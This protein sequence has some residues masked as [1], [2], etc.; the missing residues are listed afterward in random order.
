MEF[1]TYLKDDSETFCAKVSKNCGSVIFGS[2]LTYRN[3]HNYSQCKHNI[4]VVSERPEIWED[5][6]S[7]VY[8][9]N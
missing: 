2:F 7:D 8:N 9:N 1:T 4:V 5:H 3:S 6:S